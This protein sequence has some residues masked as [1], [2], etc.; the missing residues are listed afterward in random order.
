MSLEVPM[1]DPPGAEHGWGR[2]LDVLADL[3]HHAEALYD[4]ERG[5]DLLDR[6]QSEYAQ[7]TLAARLIASVDHEIA[8]EVAGLGWLAGTLERAAAD[9]LH[10]V[11]ADRDWIVPYTAVRAVGGASP[12]AVPAV[13]WSPL[14]R[15]GWTSFLRRLA[16]AQSPCAMF[17]AD[18]G[19]LDG[20]VG[21]VGADFV[22]L[23]SPERGV[24]LVP[25]AAIVAVASSGA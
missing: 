21:R 11:R 5:L 24:T 9:W 22:D 17:R 8:V 2:L 19:R 15:L 25:T 1:P 14:T 7:V 18:G 3:E 10:L 4:A 6:A 20:V 16:A 23:R 12:R 13:A